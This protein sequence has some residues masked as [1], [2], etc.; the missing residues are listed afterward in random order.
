MFF[1][2]CSRSQQSFN[3]FGSIDSNQPGAALNHRTSVL[4]RLQPIGDEAPATAWGHQRT[5]TKVSSAA[6]Q[7]RRIRQE[8]CARRRRHLG[9]CV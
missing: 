5:L 3:D 6:V 7:R 2:V 1:T 9:T 8:D 4:Q